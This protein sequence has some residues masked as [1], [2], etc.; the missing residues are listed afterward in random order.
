MS[1]LKEMIGLKFGRLTVI[2]R[3]ENSSSGQARWVCQ[4]DC[5]KI[6]TVLGTHLRTGKI[7]SCG[8]YSQEQASKAF[9]RDLTGQKF[10]KLTALERIPGN[11]NHSVYWKCQCDCGSIVE[12]A[13]SA[14]TSGHT[15][16][17]GC[18]LSQGEELISVMLQNYNIPFCKAYYFSDCYLLP[19]HPLKFDF[20]IL[21]KNGILQYLI[22]YDGNQH[23][24]SSNCGWNNQI[25]LQ[26]L[27]QRDIIKN[28]Y[29]FSHHIPLIRIPYT[30]KDNLTINDLLLSTSPYILTPDNITNYYQ[31]YN[32]SE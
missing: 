1:K 20:G 24:Y 12:V 2:E 17:C 26:E 29:C 6:K 30:K 10:G 15:K 22:E 19:S 16:S 13:S 31:I 8:C 5:G 4:C 14:L 28:N 21:N 18:L 23:F 11:R 27:H 32:Y 3:A 9:L 25:H 7:V